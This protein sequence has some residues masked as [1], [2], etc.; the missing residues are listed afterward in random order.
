MPKDTPTA[1]HA[2]THEGDHIVGIGD[3]R[4]VLLEEEGAWYAQGLELDYI[5]QGRSIEEAKENFERGLHVTVRENLRIHGTIRPLLVPAPSSVW[6]DWLDPGARTRRFRYIAFH[7][8]SDDP[9][10]S[11]LNDVSSELPFQGIDFLQ[12]VP[13]G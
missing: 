4:V 7:E 5:A 11:V 12:A 6:S 8:N 13:N 1:V 9:E 2:I 10:D 3:L